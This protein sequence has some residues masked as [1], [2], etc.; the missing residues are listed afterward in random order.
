[1]QTAKSVLRDVAKTLTPYPAAVFLAHAGRLY[2]THAPIKR[3]KKSILGGRSVW[4]LCDWHAVEITVATRVGTRHKIRFPDLIQKTIF[5]FGVWEP[6]I[7]AFVRHRLSPGDVFIDVG[8]NIGYYTCMASNLVGPTGRVHAIEALPGIHQTL[9]ENLSLNRAT[10][11]KAYNCAAYDRETTLRIFHGKP[12]N[13]G[14]ATSYEGNAIHEGMSEVSD[15][16]AKPLS[17]IVDPA[18][19]YKAKLVKI[20]VE[21]AEWFVI[22]GVKDHLCKFSPETEWLMELDP[23]AVCAQGGKLDVLLKWFEDAGYGAYTVENRYGADWYVDESNSYFNRSL[24]ELVSAAPS[25][26]AANQRDLI[27]SKTHYA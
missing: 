15:V 23:A 19:L 4:H 17:Q 14:Q 26:L 27:F 22:N 1:M 13:I 24:R 20:D 2:V 16:L 3:G 9:L 11:V 21:G 6:A 10:N 25:D 8:A 7:T 18:E 12:A 5:Y